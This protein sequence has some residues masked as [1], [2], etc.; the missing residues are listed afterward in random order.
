VAIETQVSTQIGCLKGQSS[1]RPMTWL[2]IDIGSDRYAREGCGSDRNIPAIDHDK[3]IF[4]IEGGVVG[5]D[6][7]GFGLVRNQRHIVVTVIRGQHTLSRTIATQLEMGHYGQARGW[8]VQRNRQEALSSRILFV[9]LRIKR[10]HGQFIQVGE[11]V[12]TFRQCMPVEVAREQ[13]P[14]RI[15]QFEFEEVH[16]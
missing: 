5:F 6:C 11:I 15:V 9:D 1:L 12:L 3:G 4:A 2:R 8:I 16:G 7:D 13:F 10:Y 14:S